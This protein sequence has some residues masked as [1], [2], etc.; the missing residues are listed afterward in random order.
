MIITTFED[1]NIERDVLVSL[2]EIG[3]D[4]P[5]RIQ[6]ETIP[7]IKKGY[8]VIGQSETGS[9]KTAAFGIP[10]VEKITRG[11]PVQGLILAPTRELALQNA[12]ELKKFS[13]VK[14][15]RIECI[16]GG[17][18]M[19][20][21]ISGLR[22]SEIVVGTPG[23]IMDHMRRGTLKLDNVKI[24]VLDEADRMID[25]GFIEDIETIERNLPKERQTLLFSATMPYEL[26]SVRERFTKNPKEIITDTKVKEE[27][28]KQYYC[29]VDRKVKFSV[30]VHLIKKEA[31]KLA[32]IFCN[33]RRETEIVARNLCNNGISATSLHGGLSQQRREHIVGEFHK[34]LIRILVA[35]DVAARGL[36]FKDITHIFNYSVPPNPEDYVNR[37]GRTA[38]A[39]QS[40]K[41]IILLTREDFD[42]F[43]RIINNFSFDIQQIDYSADNIR[44]L[45]FR[46]LEFQ[47][48]SDRRGSFRH[49]EDRE[50][51]RRRYERR[52]RGF[53][54]T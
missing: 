21:Q 49:H 15:L 20:P 18:S 45:P 47:E 10:L 11:L 28:L 38:R 16:Y 48:H 5:T 51:G 54:F 44:M 40:G 42:S 22:Y 9:G 41:A 50:Y 25:M 14:G 12:G 33:S 46:R 29:D 34:G 27:Y 24:F 7:L 4:E 39:G 6:Y 30:L 35:T 43:S 36:D 26:K 13:R 52:Q 19:G 32:M 2:N 8:D 1:L 31:P 17:V 3:F 37:I 53:I 23:R